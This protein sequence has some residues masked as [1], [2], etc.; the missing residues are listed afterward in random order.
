VINFLYNCGYGRPH[1]ARRYARFVASSTPALSRRVVLAGI[2]CW[3]IALIVTLLTNS[4][5]SGERSWWPW[6]CVAGLTLGLAGWA[7]LR[8][9]RG[10]AAQAE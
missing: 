10:N 1:P 8:R 5:H 6:T 3:A 7:Y 2:S 4:L 9:G